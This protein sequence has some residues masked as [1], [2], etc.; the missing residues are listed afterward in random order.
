MELLSA[1][2]TGLFVGGVL[3]LVL[4]LI[5]EQLTTYQGPRRRRTDDARMA[6]GDSPG[7]D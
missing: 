7:S 4:A 3:W 2:G 6:R 5:D 1:I